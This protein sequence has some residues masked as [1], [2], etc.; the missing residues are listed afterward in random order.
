MQNEADDDTEY[1]MPPA[2]EEYYQTKAL[3]KPDD[4][5]QLTDAVSIAFAKIIIIKKK[6]RFYF[7]VIN[8]V[9]HKLKINTKTR[10]DNVQFSQSQ[11][12]CVCVPFSSQMKQILQ[13]FRAKLHWVKRDCGGA[14]TTDGRSD[15]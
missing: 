15:R 11:E 5:L 2:E 4:Q 14:Q 7:G 13:H 9:L 8:I 12:K 1:G 3:V 6:K 10:Q